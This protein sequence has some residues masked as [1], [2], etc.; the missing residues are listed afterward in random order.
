[1]IYSVALFSWNL[2][3]WATAGAE[4]LIAAVIYWE[5]EETRRTSFQT[6]AA[7]KENYDARGDIYSEFFNVEGKSVAEK[8]EKFC[9]RIWEVKE[10]KE[11]CERSIILFNRLGQIRRY[12]LLHRRD[13]IRLFPNT[14]VLFWIM[15]QS[16]I[17][18]RRGLTGEWW[19]RD[20]RDLT[21]SCLRYLLKNP[22]PKLCL[23]DNDR[24]RRKDLVIPRSDL[25]RLQEELAPS[26]RKRLPK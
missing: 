1:V 13:Y 4:L 2:A 15:L 26:K 12:A 17:E 7:N 5:V 20:F 18:E 9:Q 23:Y 10:L 19:A 25:V 21:E 24:K 3:E 6:E 11:K 16:Y 8:S 22:D 14:V